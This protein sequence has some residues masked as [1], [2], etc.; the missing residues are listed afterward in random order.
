MLAAVMPT[1]A[2]AEP[3]SALAELDL[4]TVFWLPAEAAEADGTAVPTALVVAMAV[5]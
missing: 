3:I 5:V 1:A 2:V 4:Q